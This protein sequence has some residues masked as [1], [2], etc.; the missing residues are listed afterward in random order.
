METIKSKAQLHVESIIAKLRKQHQTQL[1]EF[2]LPTEAIMKLVPILNKLNIRFELEKRTKEDLILIEVEQRN[3]MK[4]YWLSV[5]C[6]L[7][8]ACYSR[9][10]GIYQLYEARIAEVLQQIR[11]V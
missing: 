2:S 11:S 7:F 10:N 1:L 3:S 8:K 6:E 5:L 4:I 9:A